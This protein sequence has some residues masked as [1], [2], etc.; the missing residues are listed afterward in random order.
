M[1]PRLLRVTHYPIDQ[2]ENQHKLVGLLNDLAAP[3]EIMALQLMDV[4]DE[5][6]QMH[7]GITVSHQLI[8]DAFCANYAFLPIEMK[9]R[10]KADELPKICAHLQPGKVTSYETKVQDLTPGTATWILRNGTFTEWIEGKI[11]VL[12]VSGGPGTGK[13]HLSTKVIDYLRKTPLEV[14]RRQNRVGYY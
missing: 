13:S 10:Y 9:A 11:L 8:C 7:F 2:K 5:I 6:V 3:M 4:K 1:L 14:S 12:F